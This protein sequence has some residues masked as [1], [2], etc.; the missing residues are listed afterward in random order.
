MNKYLKIIILT[1][2]L[3]VVRGNSEGWHLDVV[4][5]FIGP[6]NDIGIG[7]DPDQSYQP[8]IYLTQGWQYLSPSSLQT[9]ALPGPKCRTAI[10]VYQTTAV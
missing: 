7:Y 10:Q 9:R 3:I 2:L 1:M 6:V 5:Y 4:P 8:V